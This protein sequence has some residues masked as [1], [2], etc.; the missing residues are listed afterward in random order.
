LENA[1]EINAM[2]IAASFTESR[3]TKVKRWGACG[4]NRGRKYKF[5][6]NPHSGRNFN[7]G[8]RVTV[9]ENH[10]EIKKQHKGKE[11]E[12]GNGS[13]VD[14]YA[15]GGCS[16]CNGSEVKAQGIREGG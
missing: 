11:D 7:G 9:K 2:Q 14:R 16:S 6:G 3:H 15:Q 12:R 4:S 8:A 13:A 5:K 10:R 1:A